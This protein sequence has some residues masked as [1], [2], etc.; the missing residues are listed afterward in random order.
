MTIS[1]HTLVSLL[2]IVGTAMSILSMSLSSCA[3]RV[4]TT[5][6]TVKDTVVVEKTSEAKAGE[7]PP[8]NLNE[9]LQDFHIR[10]PESIQADVAF[11][12]RLTTIGS[13]GTLPFFEDG[14]ALELS[15]VSSVG[16]LELAKASLKGGIGSISLTLSSL[17]A[18]SE[19][20]EI[21]IILKDLNQN[22]ITK[23]HTLKIQ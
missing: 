5:K 8:T 3:T 18:N 15:F 19:T 6:D 10:A 22:L 2:L 20:A 7:M 11:E 17:E 21:T 16:R 1:K 12:L 14:D 23:R 4:V 13:E 9:V